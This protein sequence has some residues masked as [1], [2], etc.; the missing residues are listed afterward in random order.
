M[1]QTAPTTM[2]TPSANDVLRFLNEA[3]SASELAD[4]LEISGGR[5][6]RLKV[7]EGVLARR[8]AVGGMFRAAEQVIAAPSVGVERFAEI[9][10]VVRRRGRPTAGQLE[11]ERAS[12]RA[13][14]L[15]N[16]NYF[17]NLEVSP[18]K[19]VKLLQTNTNFE[20]LTCVGLNP[21][22]D[23]LE[24]V[25][26]VKQSTGYGGDICSF[27]SFEYVRFYVDLFDNGVWHDVGL[28]SVRV[29]D[30]PGQKPLCY[31]VRRDFDAI[32]KFCFTE[33]I[34]RVRA[35]L[36]WSVPPPANTPGFNPVYGNVLTVQVQIQPRKFIILDDILKGFELAKIPIPD[37]IGPIINVLDPKARL[38]TVVSQPLSLAQRKQLY[39]NKGVPVHRFAFPEAQALIAAPGDMGNIFA[40]GGESPL[41]QLGLGV[42]EISDLVGKIQV[43]ADGD[44]SFEEL[45][46]IGLRPNTDLLEGVITVK[47]SSGYSGGLCSDGSTEYVAF[48]MDFNDGAGFTYLGT[49]T[50]QVHD[51]QTLPDED[52]HYAVFRQI[53]LDEKVLPCDL[54]PRVIRLRAILS[55][56]TPPPPGNPNWVPVW[57]NREECLV[58]LRSGQPVGHEPRIETVGDVGVDDIN[59]F[60]GLA[61][62]ELEIASGSVLQAPFGGEV[63]I[64]GRIFNPPNSFGGGASPFK[65][66]IEIR[67]DGEPDWHPLTNT[68]TVKVSSNP[69]GILPGCLGEDL[70]DVTLTAVDD[71]DGLGEGWYEYLEDTTGG[72]QRFLVLDTLGRWQTTSADEGM[73]RIRIRA[74]DPST[75][76]PTVFPGT[77]VVRVRIDNTSPSAP[78]LP[79]PPP[80]EVHRVRLTLD[81]F[82]FEGV[83]NPAVPCG[84]YPVGSILSGTYEAHD[85]G[86]TDLVNQHFGSLSLDVIP[87][88]PANGA[89]PEIFEAGGVPLIA[90][91]PSSRS[92]PT[93]P[94]TGESGKWRLD[95]GMMDPCG[96][97]IRLYTSDRTNVGSGAN[98]GF[99][100]ICDIGFCLHAPEPE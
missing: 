69:P 45:R 74:K 93:V 82:T 17:G 41:V 50:V 22:L 31:A 1:E 35:I 12:F 60:S 95:T 71:A 78:P 77:K 21:P 64:T 63:T 28:A 47:K 51:L 8:A 67:K 11:P 38:Q 90:P 40:P 55:W 2:A 27:G 39:L 42:D 72:L 98:V 3:V 14:L 58:Q 70:C 94:T 92:F 80:I 76:P 5:E 23:R 18:Y 66:R 34:V 36:S 68:I 16:P 26:H 20:E 91:F 9:S 30:I 65:Y 59:V 37:P 52:V 83:T 33:N 56:E 85:P 86:M 49:A 99:D 75:S 79:L 87:D 61:T 97:V 57:G 15:G 29:H 53:D 24:A 6:A 48:W 7:A 13:L 88:G 96:Y 62:G 43:V 19:P 100:E 10:E 44:T 84:E 89:T 4:Q 54:G 32:R 25:I 73:W 81:E 46:C